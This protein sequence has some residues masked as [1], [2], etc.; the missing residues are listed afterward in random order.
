MAIPNSRRLNP[1]LYYVGIGALAVVAFVVFFGLPNPFPSHAAKSREIAVAAPPPL[2][3]PTPTPAWHL[4]AI[5]KPVL[6]QGASTPQP[7]ASPTPCGPC[8]E[9]A[10]RYKKAIQ[11]D[12]EISNNSLDIPQAF[13]TPAAQPIYASRGG[14]GNSADLGGSLPSG[15]QSVGIGTSGVVSPD[16]R[17]PEPQWPSPAAQP[18]QEI[19]SVAR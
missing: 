9:A 8:I 5:V 2:P 1:T 15:I 10:E 17:T 11:G 19:S 18:S 3:T 14:F 4:P 12:D 13:P 16:G 6:H 7:K